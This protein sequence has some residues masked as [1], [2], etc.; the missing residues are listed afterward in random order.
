MH[1]TTTTPPAAAEDRLSEGV[2]GSVDITFMVLA[3]AA[4]MAIVVATM[5]IAFALGNGM[6]VAGTYAMSGLAITLFA[7]GY[8]RLIP[9]IRNAGAFYAIISQT[10]GKVVGLGGS[11]V[12]LVSYMALSC[13]TLGALS[14]FLTGFLH[15]LGLD[16]LHWG[17]VALATVAILA[18]LSYFRIDFTAKLLAVALGAEVLAILLLDFAILHAEGLGTPGAVFAPSVVFAPGFGVAAIYAFN[19]VIG[20]E[21]TAIYQEEARNPRVSIPRATYAAIVVICLFYVFTAYAFAV[22]NGPGIAAIA[23]KDP[24]AFVFGMARHYLGREAETVLSL[25]VISSAFAAALGLFN[26]STRYMFALARDGVL[27]ALLARTRKANGAPF[28]AG[29]PIVAVLSIVI[30]LF[31]LAGLDPL[32]SLT[33]ALTGFGSVGLMALLCVTA[34]AVPFFLRAE[35]GGFGRVSLFPFAGGLLLLAGTVMSVGNYPLLTGTDSVLVNRLPILLVAIALAGGLQAVAL[36]SRRPDIF[37]RIGSSRIA[38][39]PSSQE[40]TP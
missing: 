20:F 9:Y 36:R 32:L 21:A 1:D 33:T 38:G 14:Y 4:P 15:T 39:Q 25:L 10:F 19:S 11:Y 13:A 17:A 3:V 28:N 30:T 2:L 16:F 31:A 8:V 40:K 35:T 34:F 23:G 5:P 6:G 27:P 18:T 7:I 29:L 12:A 24:G 26:N 37:A 22:A